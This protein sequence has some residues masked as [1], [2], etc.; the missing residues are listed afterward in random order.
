MFLWITT[1]LELTGKAMGYEKMYAQKNLMYNL[2]SATEFFFYLFFLWSMS[3][4]RVLKRVILGIIIIF[5]LFFFINLFFFEGLFKYNEDTYVVGSIFLILSGLAFLH[6][7]SMSETKR[8]DTYRWAF[9]MLVSALLIF[10]I[11]NVFHVAV[12]RNLER[13]N[14][15]LSNTIYRIIN[16]N[17][18]LLLYS[19]FSI[20]FIMELRLREDQKIK[21]V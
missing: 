6:E 18:N 12:K 16:H 3:E 19:F 1:A 13:N 11:G 15:L 10:Y 5:G 2:F 20:A 9:L 14:P 21:D 8:F 4:R 7:I 17:L